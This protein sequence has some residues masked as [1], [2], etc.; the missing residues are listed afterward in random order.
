MPPI[1]PDT[2]FPGLIEG[3]NFTPPIHLPVIYANV[4]DKIDTSNGTHAIPKSYTENNFI[5]Q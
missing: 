5:K 3:H 4:S 2:V 1:N